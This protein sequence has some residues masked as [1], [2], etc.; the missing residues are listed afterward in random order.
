MVAYWTTLFKCSYANAVFLDW[1]G[2]S[3]AAEAGEL[4]LDDLPGLSFPLFEPHLTAVLNGE[5]N[6]VELEWTPTGKTAR[7]AMFRLAPDFSGDEV[8]GFMMTGIS[9]S[10]D[11]AGENVPGKVAGHSSPDIDNEK[12]ENGLSKKLEQYSEQLREL[13]SQYWGT[14]GDEAQHL[15]SVGIMLDEGQEMVVRQSGKETFNR[16]VNLYD[17]I[18]RAMNS[19]DDELKAA[20]C[21]VRVRVSPFIYVH[22][23]STYMESIICS[24]VGNALLNRSSERTLVVELSLIVV[25]NETVLSIKDNG[26]GIDLDT[27][28]GR[29]DGGSREQ[30]EG[31]EGRQSSLFSVRQQV[32]AMGGYI[33]VESEPDKG[34][35]FR[36]YFKTKVAGV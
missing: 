20:G 8:R 1:F 19:I 7:K 14:H 15:L 21:S 17:C 9:V 31:R 23:N 26:K 32:Y 30:T 4:N 29:V 2:K 34:T 24:F 5:T 13:L 11:G 3:I 27:F 16:E 18:A 6:D 28:Y 22:A 36:I 10:P 33:G 25:G 35:W 12:L